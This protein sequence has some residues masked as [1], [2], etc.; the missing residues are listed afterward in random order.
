MAGVGDF[1]AA[2]FA[3]LGPAGAVLALYLIFVVDAAVFPALPEL[4]VV[5]FF[6]AYEG[7]IDP[8]AWAVALCA[9]AMAGEATGNSLLYLVVRRAVATNRM[10]KRVKRL[11]AKWVNFLVVSDERVILLNRIAPV[12]PMVGAF[13]AVMR[14]NLRRSLAYVVVGAGAKYAALLALAG[15]LG[16]VMSPAQSRIAAVVLVLGIVAVSLAAAR[17]RRR[18]ILSRTAGGRRG[19]PPGTGPSGP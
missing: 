12:V 3:F 16:I 6:V 11:M 1:L 14:W 10:P 2:L 15:G 8:L 5:V 13:I 18:R 19:G 9:T 7:P 4:F 17:V